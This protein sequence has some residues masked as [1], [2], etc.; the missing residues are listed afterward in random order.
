M[1]HINFDFQGQHQF[2][3]EIFVGINIVYEQIQK[4]SSL[5]KDNLIEFFIVEQNHILRSR[6]DVVP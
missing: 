5:V 2:P 1:I 4:I 3:K 6:M